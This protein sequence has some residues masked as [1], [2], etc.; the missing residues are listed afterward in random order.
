LVIKRDN[1]PEDDGW[2]GPLY[3]AFVLFIG[4][5]AIVAVALGIVFFSDLIKKPILLVTDLLPVVAAVA[6]IIALYVKSQA[7]KRR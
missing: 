5:L 3:Q 4:P 2:W 1:Y 6:V 7:L